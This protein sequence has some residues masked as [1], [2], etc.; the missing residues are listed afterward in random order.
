[1]TARTLMVV[2]THSG[3]GKSTLVAALCRI[4]ARQGY[5]VAPFKAQNMAL[6][7][8]VTPEGHEIGRATLA[9]AEAAGVPPHVDM[10]PVLLKPE[11]D[12]RSQIILNGRPHGHITADNWYRIKPFLWREVTAALD[13]LRQRFD[14]VI[15]EGAGSPAEINLK[16]GDI[17]NLRVA[18]HA[19]SPTLLVGDIDQGGVFAALVGTMVLLEPAEREL[20]RGFVINKFRGNPGLLG[21][22]L[23]LLRSHAFGRP[24]LGVIPHLH[25]IG[26]AAEDS[27][28][29][30]RRRE[31]RGEAAPIDVAVIGTAVLDIAVIA[32]PQLS[33]FDDFDPLA[34]EEGVRVRF[35]RRAEDLGAP[36]AIILPGTK[37]TLADLAWLRGSGLADRIVALARSGTAVAGICGGYQMMGRDLA[38]PD[39]IEAAPGAAATG[40]GLLSLRTRFGGGKRTVQVRGTLGAPRGPF[41]A[42]AGLPIRGYEIHVGQS[43]LLAGS[44]L[45]E[46][47]P[48]WG[49]GADGA[50]DR[51]GRIWGTYLHGLF[52][53]DAVREAWLRS[54]GWRGTA[55]AFERQTAYDRLADHVAAHL[56]LGALEALI[57]GE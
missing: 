54:L 7:A 14:L 12:C 40:L 57:W 51:T 28:E 39:G 20:I 43:E 22:G 34:R 23:E 10:N 6:N 21:D 36:A 19:G 37:T 56:D 50:V 11:G 49:P 16:E 45:W 30:P 29:I 4:F 17:V 13:R 24:T 53:N 42:L 44:A 47:G 26:I 8:G 31:T 18:R 25:E 48:P 32:L 3:A 52:D 5:R 46:I 55:R 33:N 41:A 1:M 2:G 9:Q 15:L 27:T 35:V 38:D